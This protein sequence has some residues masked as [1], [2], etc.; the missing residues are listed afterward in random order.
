MFNEDLGYFEPRP[1]HE[2]LTQRPKVWKDTPQ[3]VVHWGGLPPKELM[4]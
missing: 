3:A 4:E 1:W 2:D